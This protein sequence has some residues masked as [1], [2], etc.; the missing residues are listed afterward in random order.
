MKK[1]IIYL[2]G[3]ALLATSI[4]AGISP[5]SVE[6]RDSLGVDTNGDGTIDSYL[7]STG[8]GAFFIR[9]GDNITLS[10][11]GDTLYIN[12]ATPGEI[13]TISDVG[14]GF[15]ITHD[16][17]GVDF[18]IKTFV[19]GTGI[20]L[21]TATANQLNITNDFG[22]SIESA[23]IADGTVNDADIDWGTG[24]NE[25]NMDDIGDGSTN[26]AITLT[27]ETNFETAYT[28]S[29]DNT[30]AH[31]DYMVNAGDTVSGTYDFSD[32]DIV[33][34]DSAEIKRLYAD[35]IFGTTGSPEIDFGNNDVSLDSIR[36]DSILNNIRTD[37]VL[38]GHP[39]D[40]I[41]AD[42]SDGDILQWI[43]ANSEWQ[44]V[45][46]SAGGSGAFDDIDAGNDTARYVQPNGDT[47]LIIT[48]DETGNVSL[49]TGHESDNS[50]QTLHITVDT[51]LISGDAISDFNGDGL[52]VNSNVLTVD[53]GTSIDSTEIGVDQVNDLDINFGTGTDQVSTDDIP[54]GTNKY[55][56][57]LSDSANWSTA[58]SWGDHST[59]N[60]LDNDDVNVDTASWNAAGAGAGTADSMGVDTDGNGT[61]DAYLYSTTA[62]A[63]HIKKGANITLTVNTDTLT[64]AGA[65]GSGT[66]DSI[67]VDTDGDGTIDGYMYSTVGGSSNIKEGTGC[68][69]TLDTDTLTIATTLGTSI[70]STE[71]DFTTMDEWV[72]DQIGENMTGGTQTGITVTPQESTNDVDFVVVADSTVVTDEGI[73]LSKDL[74]TFT[75]AELE[76]ELSDVTALFT[77]NVT[78]DVTVTGD[79]SAIGASSLDSNM[80]NA[81]E[82]DEYIADKVGA[83]VTGNTETNI[84]VDYIEA[85]N[86]LDFVVSGTAAW[87]Q[88]NGNDSLRL[89]QKNGVDTLVYITADTT[90][91]T[92]KILSDYAMIIGSEGLTA[93][94]SLSGVRIKAD[95]V[96][97][98]S[99]LITE[100]AGTGLTVTTNQLTVDL[101]TSIESAEITNQTITKDDIDTTAS[102]FVFDDAYRATSDIA[103][104]AYITKAYADGLSGTGE[105]NTL[106]DT[107]TFN[108]TSGFGLAGGKTGTALKVKGLIEGSNITITASGDSAYTITGSAGGSGSEDS[109]YFNTEASATGTEY[110]SINNLVKVRPGTGITLT[111]EDSTNFDMMRI[112]STLGTSIEGT[113][114]TDGTV[115]TIDLSSVVNTILSNAVTAYGWGDWDNAN[116]DSTNFGDATIGWEDIDTAGQSL[117][118]LGTSIDST[119]I[120]DGSVSL[121]KDLHTFT[122]AELAT[123]ITDETGT[124]VS[125]FSTAPTFTDKITADSLVIDSIGVQEMDVGGNIT[126][127][128][129]VD[130]VD[131]GTLAAKVHKEDLKHWQFMIADPNNFFDTD[132]MVCIKPV[133]EKAITVTRVDVTCDAAPAT[134]PAMALR[135]AD[136]FISRTTPTTIGVITTAVGVKVL[137]SFSDATIPASRCVYFVFTADPIDEIKSIT[138]DITYTID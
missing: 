78:G 55:D 133:T 97:V 14:A 64:I 62:G 5:P 38:C 131:V 61:V 115:N 110:K 59:Q 117:S 41:T 54:E 118:H 124:G 32:G 6:V 15:Q 106:S 104:S 71:I 121:S 40:T 69:L 63:F 27:Q 86:T 128:G 31:T 113:E 136:N 48:S 95:T 100:F 30:Q 34:I 125:V 101:G 105:T 53:L 67:G 56:Q 21:D 84:S 42:L 116:H 129:T 19:G 126:I 28:H 46:Q 16:K 96:E 26:A 1:Y 138:V 122:S 123:K 10:V 114:I 60:Y 51:I 130:T 93:F 120:T 87:T 73:S 68:T 83:M 8:P 134:E 109:I 77:N 82:I 43:D 108:N 92:V 94:D 50:A 99:D 89:I 90:N 45:A 112:N 79:V 2:I 39:I 80:L 20:T 24:T 137:T 70:D 66:A 7:Y 36:W 74:H 9:K 103:D 22:T 12:S 37:T 65:A 13:N 18:P 44:P 58:Y 25:V 49:K 111:R 91:D 102:D 17:I 57:A 4:L 85:D 11:S 3:S 132:S 76:T 119:E 35:T 75:E 135:F 127:A 81:T 88:Q 29:Q 72:S 107:G 23:E 98:G 47:A 52:S 33:D